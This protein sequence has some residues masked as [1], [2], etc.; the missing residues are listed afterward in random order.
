MAKANELGD[1]RRSQVVTT[2]GPG[3]IVDFRAGGFG[4]AAISV[5]AAGLEEWDRHAT[6]P[7]LG[8]PQTVYEPRLQ[9]QLGV[10]GFR[11]PPVAEQVAPGHYA[12][13][14][15]KLAGTRFP[16]WLQCPNCHVLRGVQGWMEDPGDP[17]LYCAT[18]SKE[19]GG[20]N[21]IH[22]VPV[23]FIVMCEFGH[24][25]EFPWHWW[26]S[27]KEGCSAKKDL[28]LEGSAT[29]GL[30]GLILSC[31][32]CGARKPME[33][34]FSRGALPPQCRG[35]RP[36]LGI[37]ADELNCQQ[38]P[39][40]VQR[41]ASNIYFP[42]VE[43]ALD[44]PPWSDDLQKKIGVRWAML[45]QADDAEKRLT[46]IQALKLASIFG[47][48]ESELASLIE[49]RITRI[50]MPNRNL[51]WEEYQQF[52]QHKKPFGEN[53][54]F[55]IRPS[56]PPPEFAQWFDSVVKAT[57]LREVRAVHG[58]TRMHP[59][60]VGDTD[61]IAK[62]SLNKKEWL[63]AIENRGEGIF[64]RL[65][66]KELTRWEAIPA[67]IER[68]KVLKKEYV[69]AWTSKKRHGS[70]R[71]ISSRFLLLHSLSHALIR[72]LAL[73]CGYSSASLRERLYVGEGEWD[74]AGVLIFTSS[75]D[76]DGTLGGLVRQGESANF[77]S[78][79][80]ECITSMMWCSSDPLCIEGL[81]AL[82][83]PGSGAACHSCLLSSETSCE[84]F[85]SLLD[86]AFLV[87]TP[88]IPSLGFFKDMLASNLGIGR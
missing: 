11:L 39:R 16:R 51:R 37:D 21:R 83:S 62:I 54:E 45:E 87:G 57:R 30:A 58:F 14:V 47:K 19:A 67:V 80:E 15:G 23:R 66:Q 50:K 88:S 46:I 33:G 5:V 49:D 13:N 81:H 8:H 3:A 85:N 38:E 70:P 22:V 27:H 9:K 17:A 31:V 40:V 84:E 18:C 44:I 10:N 7:G 60:M 61:R 29:A 63:P 28:K 69:D 71:E 64:L 24:L 34:C 77:A 52:V 20:R 43:S 55:E 65:N 56:P 1:I 68:T 4:G 48:D 86:R 25:D 41:G 32:E 59:P 76:A 26:V 79:M 12:K 73:N 2:H 74:M 72:Q 36:W 78:I 6:P 35:K 82:S 53:T 42:V 75:P